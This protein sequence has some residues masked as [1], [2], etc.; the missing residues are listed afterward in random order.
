MALPAMD[1]GEALNAAAQR[2]AETLAC[3][4]ADAF[5]IDE[6]KQ[7]LVAVGTSDTALGH[8]QRAL[9]LDLLPLANGGRIVEV[10][11]NGVGCLDNHVDRDRNELPGI[12]VGL[13]V[14][15]SLSA[16]LD[17]NG[18]RRGVL[19]AVSIRPDAFQPGDL[20][21][22]EAAASWIG[23]LAHRAELATQA[24]NAEL[25]QG[26]RAG[27]DEVITVLAHDVRN[28]LHP[29]L[30]RLQVMRVRA[31]A[32][33]HVSVSEIDKAM[34][35]VQRLARLSEDLLDLRRLD[36]GLFTLNWAA[37]DLAALARETGASLATTSVPVNVTGL[38]EIVLIGDANRLRQALENVVSNAVK[39]SPSGK[40]VQIDV[41]VRSA[42]EGE[43]RAVVEVT[44][45]GPGIAPKMQQVLFERF[46]SD[47]KSRGLGLGLYLARRIAREH[48]GDLSVTSTP[49]AG[50]KFRLE[51]PLAPPPSPRGPRS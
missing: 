9:G 4:K 44:D 21:F 35:S 5:L 31:A 2:I 19:S 37:L 47:A 46:V 40:S 10:F 32:G 49:G 26:R 33:E 34:R 15:S 1:L 45:Q 39:Y 8:Q 24:R 17:V 48:D 16:V 6:S 23:M 22:L 20:P 7:T 18:V 50:S 11:K 3:E 13:G 36:E 14:R 29:L 51:L 42:E 43:E 38:S 27:A 41:S 28:H 30:A 12:V 25:E